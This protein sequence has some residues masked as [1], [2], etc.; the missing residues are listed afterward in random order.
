MDAPILPQRWRRWPPAAVG[1]LLPEVK[2]VMVAA[3]AVVVEDVVAE[4][5]GLEAFQILLLG[6]RPTP[7]SLRSISF[8]RSRQ[9]AL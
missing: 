4:V 5:M 6:V 2:R 1:G 7:A 8:C 9:Q 3:A